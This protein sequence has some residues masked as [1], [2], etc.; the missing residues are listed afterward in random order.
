MAPKIT[1]KAVYTTALQNSA[2][3]GDLGAIRLMI[4]HGADV[5]AY[6]PLGRTP[7][8]Y[9]AVSDVLPVEAVK[10]L[11][12]RGADV[13]AMDKH[14]NSGDTGITVLDIAKRNGNPEIIQLLTTAGA[15]ASPDK[16]VALKPRKGNTI[17]AAVQD[18]L[19]LL[20]R[21]DSTFVAKAGCVSC[22]NNSMAAMAVGLARKRGLPVDESISSKQVMLNAQFLEKAREQLHQGYSFAVGDNFSDVIWEYVLLGLHAENY[23]PN[24]STDAAAL[25]ILT[26][27][28]PNGDWPYPHAD[29]RPPI[30]LN[31]ITQTA[32]SMRVLQVYAPK[33]NQAAA[34]KAIRLAASWMAK[35]KTYNSEDRSW[36]VMGLAWAGTEKVAL[37]AAMKELL[38]AQ[39][40]DGGWSDLPTSALGSSAFATG[41]SLV[42]LHTAGMPVSDPAF[43]H[44][45]KYLLDTQQED[46]SWYVKTRALAFQP[47]FEADFPHGHDQWMSAAGTSWASMA[48][49][50]ALPEKGSV[51]AALLH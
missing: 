34:D 36:R 46:G 17:R 22:H 28:S 3:F 23:K 40:P 12:E 33:P 11:I 2:V 7:L 39:R 41:E 31:Y 50:L 45:I 9:A 19:P 44:G 5:N 29:T 48:L 15:K 26:R 13:N 24:L 30:C 38:A 49:T 6:D 35:A 37:Q 32:L 25:N 42:A 43:Q 4:D 27:Q 8:M 21:S 18:S 20:Q 51:T 10:L 47:T 14:K 16:S 1:D